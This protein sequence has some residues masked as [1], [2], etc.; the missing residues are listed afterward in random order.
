M[1]EAFGRAGGDDHQFVDADSVVGVGRRG[2]GKCSHT[3]C[4]L[5]GRGEQ[6]GLHRDIPLRQ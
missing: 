3:Q 5:G 2:Y 6:L 4:D 1:I